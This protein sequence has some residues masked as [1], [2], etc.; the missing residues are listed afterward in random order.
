MSAGRFRT[1]DGRSLHDALGAR[2]R[3]RRTAACSPSFR[4]RPGTY[5]TNKRALYQV[6]Y[7]YQ[8]LGETP[9]GWVVALRTDKVDATA[10][11][12]LPDGAENYLCSIFQWEGLS[13][14]QLK[15][16][17]SEPRRWALTA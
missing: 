2:I 7:G 12:Y 10:C 16:V 15:L 9:F 13:H 4:F 3:Q 6:V 1:P 17:R 14:P 5:F 8:S 11:G